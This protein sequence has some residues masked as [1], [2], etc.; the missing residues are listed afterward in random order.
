MLISLFISLLFAEDTRSND[1]K[2]RAAGVYVIREVW[3]NSED[4]KY[5]KRK[6][7]QIYKE[8]I[9]KET[10]KTIEFILPIAQMI[11]NREIK[12]EWEF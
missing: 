11:V 1:D 7:K 6:G 12:Y 3:K 9:D 4:L 10:R 2:Y 5:I 8:N